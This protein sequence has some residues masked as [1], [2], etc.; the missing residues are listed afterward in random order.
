MKY[1]WGNRVGKERALRKMLVAFFFILHTSY[2]ILSA[3]AQQQ[4]NGTTAPDCGG[5]S[6]T[7]TPTNA[8]TNFLLCFEENTDPY[9]HSIYSSSGYLGMY[10]ASTGDTA[11]VTITC[12]RYPAMHKVFVL[13]ANQAI[14]YNITDDTLREPLGAIDT[15]RDL[16]IVSDEATDERVVQ[17]Q[18]TSPIVCYGMDYKRWSADAFCALPEEYSGTE[19]RV[20]S[21]GSSSGGVDGG[22][23]SGEFAVA[24]FQ[25]NTVVTIQPTALTPNGTTG[26]VSESFTLQQGECIQVQADTIGRGNPNAY[27]DLTGSIVRSNHPVAVYGGHVKTEIPDFWVRPADKYVDRDML[28]EAMPPTSAWGYS[29]VLEP[30]GLDSTHAFG[31]D[32]DLMRVLSL[33][34]SNV[35]LNGRPWVTLTAGQFADTLITG[36]TL[37]A[38]VGP[39][40]GP[41]LV[42][43]MEHS[44]YAYAGNGDPFMA[45]VPPMEQTYNNYTFFL[46]PDTNF[47]YQSVI[48]AAD[49]NCQSAVSIDGNPISVSEFTPVPGS[50]NRRAFSIA[51]H[52]LPPG[53]H[54]VTTSSISQQAFTILGY[55]V[56]FANAYGYA[57]GQL[58]VPKRSIRIEPPP[59]AI[60][61]V[62]S[63]AIDFHNTAYQ[64]AYVDSAIFVPDN[65]KEAAFGIHPLETVWSDIGRMDIGA[66]AEIHLVPDVPLTWPVSGTVKIYSH[67]PSYFLI[68]PAEMH[69]TLYPIAAADVEQTST[70]ALA[71]TAA[72]NPFSSFTTLNFSTPKSADITIILYDELGRIARR[73]AS[74]EFAAGPHSVRIDRLGL[75]NGVYTCA[76][77]SEKWNLNARIPIVAGE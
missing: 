16:W 70:L 25:D 28:L 69:F 49:T 62:H 40:S 64:P 48:I 4:N 54:T 2:F 55:G 29:F 57:A 72:P 35:M 65:P 47:R 44:S 21:Y 61:N 59:E 17:V 12:N 9:F 19:Y 34:S 26:G 24:A 18:S 10:I 31:P 39:R 14:S 11:T 53:V 68:E 5:P 36:P 37:V 71:V 3:H 67:L 60:G 27:L 50:A 56:G 74:S 51:E 6:L 77:R 76:I 1:E 46:P 32:G 20:M 41:L 52:G 23:A 63:N 73:V 8:G 15:M 43:E 22:A 45:I 7:S 38:S 75:A 13:A 30:V 42:A 58:L 33:D 66:S